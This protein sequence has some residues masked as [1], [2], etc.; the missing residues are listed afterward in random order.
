MTSTKFKAAVVKTA[1]D[2]PAWIVNANGQLVTM[3][4]AEMEIMDNGCLVIS[5]DGGIVAVYSPGHWTSVVGKP[6]LPPVAKAA[7][8]D[9][10]AQP[11]KAT[12]PEPAFVKQA[13]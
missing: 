12:G 9:T 11:A 6:V 3:V 7:E 13:P 8:P 1:P 2:A 5:D 10:S 4:G